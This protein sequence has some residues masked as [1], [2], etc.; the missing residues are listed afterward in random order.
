MNTHASLLASLPSPPWNQVHLGPLSIRLYGLSIAV[1]VIVA[2]MVSSKRWE[3]RG[4]DPDDITTLALWCV[5]AGVIGARLYHV[6]TDYR[7]YEGRW[8]DALKITQGGLGIPGGITAG[9]LTGLVV[10]R[11]KKLPA[12]E[13]L[14]VV[15]P[16]LPLAQAIGRLGN[17]FNQEV[18]G[19]PTSLPWG[20]QID[21]S[22]RPVR[23]ATAETFHPTF[24]YEGL[25]NV[26]L[27][28]LLLW[29]DHHRRLRKGELFALY[30]LGYS[31]GRLW[32]ESL[33]SDHASLVLGLRINTVMSLIG[34]IVTTAVLVHLHRTPRPPVP[35][36]IA[37]QR[38][39]N[40]E[41]APVV[42]DP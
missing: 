39:W 34:I 29:L 32:V 27:A 15:A 33:R 13:L 42:E 16:A 18:F 21:P 2:V 35:N 5:P 28:V 9:V 6:A 12:V 30:V 20:L 8:I 23:Y 24:L 25:W 10:V 36:G 11:V 41:Q 1:G 38:E 19:R 22:F 3:R 37:P 14:D 26:G 4:G 40:A 17:W 7:M 31:I